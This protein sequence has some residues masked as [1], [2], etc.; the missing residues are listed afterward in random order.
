MKILIIVLTCIL[1]TI[2]TFFMIR[3]RDKDYVIAKV[4]D[5]RLKILPSY[6]IQQILDKGF[7]DVDV[8]NILSKPNKKI[9]KFIGKVKRNEWAILRTV[10]SKDLTVTSENIFDDI[11]VTLFIYDNSVEYVQIIKYFTKKQNGSHYT[12]IPFD[13]FNTSTENGVS[14][15]YLAIGEDIIF[16]SVLTDRD[17]LDCGFIY[18]YYENQ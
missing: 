8:T 5:D 12:N 3:S 9:T 6:S 10:N 1:I 11:V 13:S 18:S 7:A 14:T 16:D 4:F 2:V 17:L 15:V